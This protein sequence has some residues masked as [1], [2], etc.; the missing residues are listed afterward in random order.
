M[1][2]AEERPQPLSADDIY[3]PSGTLAASPRALYVHVPFCLH[4]CGY[5]D[6]TL[7]ADRDELIPTYLQALRNEFSQLRRRYE[8]DTIFV[9]GGTPTHLTESQLHELF[10]IV[11]EHF[12]LTDHGEFSVEANPDGLDGNKLKCL[13]QRGVNRLS[14]GVQ[15]FD[16]SI[17]KTLE[18]AHS[19]K[20]ATSVINEAAA[21]LENVSIDLI[22]AVPSQTMQSWTDSLQTAIASAVSHISTY[23]LTYEKGTDFFSRRKRG[24]LHPLPDETERAMYAAA[25]NQ[26]HSA[27]FR[28]YEISNFARPGS[29]CRHNRTYWSASE[30]FAFGPGAARYINGV[31][32][33]NSRNVNTWIKNWTAGKV[34]I[35]E[36]ERLSADDQICEAVFL[37]LRQIDGIAIEDFNRRFDVSV[38]ELFESAIEINV[39]RGWL[40]I[41][42]SHIRL[43]QEG[44]FMADSVVV[45]FL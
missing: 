22:F 28:H 8:V 21:V 16:D 31:R 41:T 38:V 13:H 45:D 3:C 34:S 30:Y 5:C 11:D 44:R 26:L 27:G 37:G 40:E 10:D 4:R 12:D 35:Q 25:M 18:R 17:L 29:E 33:T 15:S 1:A 19:S 32:S 39:E 14:L 20:E 24:Q 36:H 6:F 2:Q 23:G 7:V 42:D 43:T 9:G